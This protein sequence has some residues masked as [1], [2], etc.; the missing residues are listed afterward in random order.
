MIMILWLNEWILIFTVKQQQK[1][2]TLL[3][4][5][6]LINDTRSAFTAYRDFEVTP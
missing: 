1:G 4:W 6:Q 3:S 5:R 2:L